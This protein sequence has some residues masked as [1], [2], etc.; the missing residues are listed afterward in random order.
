MNK[1]NISV[2][3]VSADANTAS[4]IETFTEGLVHH[5]LSLSVCHNTQ[6]EI[7]NV[8]THEYVDLV[9]FDTD[10]LDEHSCLNANSILENNIS[11]LFL[12]EKE[13]IEKLIESKFNFHLVDYLV[14]PVPDE[15]LKHKIE[16]Y[17][18]NILHKKASQYL[19]NAYDESVI[20]SKTDIK[21]M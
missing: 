20:A 14:K 9:V 16:I 7:T 12:V 21:G 17:L 11:I 15:F 18:Q 19:L 6:E 8:L 1:K 2:L 5:D 3:I 10:D 4:L 13:D